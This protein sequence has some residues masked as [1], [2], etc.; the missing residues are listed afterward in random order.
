[1]IFVIDGET[2]DVGIS[3]LDRKTR[4]EKEKI[5]TTLDGKEHYEIIGTYIDY[6]LTFV[7]RGNNIKDYDRL[8]ELVSEPTESHTVEL[9]YNQKTLTI[10]ATISVSNTQVQYDF[11]RF[12]KWSE[13]KITFSSIEPRAE[14]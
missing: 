9:P 14:Q 1:M 12:R 8:Y 3:K 7:C 6:I 13:M 5:G 4:I 10:N 2:F 11:N